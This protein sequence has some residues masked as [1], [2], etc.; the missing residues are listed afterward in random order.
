MNVAK[1]LKRLG[2]PAGTSEQQWCAAMKSN[3]QAI[4]AMPRGGRLLQWRSGRYS[5][6][7]VAVLFDASHRFVKITHRYQC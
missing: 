3:P 6:Q 1:G 2:E 5:V 7:R 4:S